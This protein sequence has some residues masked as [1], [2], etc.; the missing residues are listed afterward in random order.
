MANKY[1]HHTEEIC[2]LQA[3]VVDL[4]DRSR[5]NNV[6]FRGIPE[7]INLKV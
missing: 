1:D 7:T 2:F 3:K 5:R 4:E 6:K